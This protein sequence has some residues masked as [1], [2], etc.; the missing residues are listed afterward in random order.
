MNVSA[1]DLNLLPVLDAVLREGNATR[2]AARLGVT[3]PAVSNALARLRRVL[4]DPLF[5]KTRRG[6]SPTPRALELRPALS[7]ALD[8]LD[9][10]LSPRES[11]SLATT[12]RQWSLSFADHYA[13][14]LLPGL[15]RW[16]EKEAPSASIRVI[17]LE[18]MIANDELAGG[19]VDVYVGI[20]GVPMPGCHV[21]RYFQDELVCV[22]SRRARHVRTLE[23]F[24]SRG[25]VK[26]AIAPGR[27]NEVDEALAPLQRHRR[28]ALTVPHFSSA[29]EVVART[30]L[31]TVVPRN[32][33]EL[34]AD[35]L[36]VEKLPVDVAPL[37]VSMYWHHRVHADPGVTALREG[38]L[39][40]VG[41]DRRLRA[42][43]PSRR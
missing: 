41:P 7:L 4:G 40:L 14:L 5:V 37:S 29:L 2:A 12:Q 8:Q 3:Q 34:H 20:P 36:Y 43:G 31:L 13:L 17:P 6:L 24:L 39:A 10:A 19:G 1:I 33:A 30:D 27:G 22:G 38:L 28:I 18:R 25:H 15:M 16:I 32:L 11:F 21:R 23:Q 35:R 42:P 26:I 9:R